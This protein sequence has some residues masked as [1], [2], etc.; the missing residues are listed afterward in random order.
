MRRHYDGEYIKNLLLA[1]KNIR[2]DDGISVSLGADIIV[3]FPGETQQDFMDTFNLIK[4]IGIQKVHAFPFS[5]HE[6]GESV[7]A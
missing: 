2:R 6:M 7:P 3:G 5:P 1:T 4:E